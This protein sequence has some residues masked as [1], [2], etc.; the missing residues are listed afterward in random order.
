MSA[1]VVGRCVWQTDPQL[2]D[3]EHT[4]NYENVF[5]GGVKHEIHSNLEVEIPDDYNTL[6]IRLIPES[7]KKMPNLYS[8]KK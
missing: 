1:S 3:P 4:H 8:T 5:Q 6:C 7:K 2:R